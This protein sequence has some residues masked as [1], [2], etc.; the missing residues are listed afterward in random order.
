MSDVNDDTGESE[1]RTEG[2][3]RSQDGRAE[4]RCDSVR[5]VQ[6]DLLWKTNLNTI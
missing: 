2:V 6:C 1:E 4:S 5:R 3:D